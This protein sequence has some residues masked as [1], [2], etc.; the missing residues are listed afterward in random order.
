MAEIDSQYVRIQRAIWNKCSF[1]TLSDDGKLLFLYLDTC[2]HGN[3]MN[4]FVMPSGYACEDLGWKMERF[5][6]GLGELLGKRLVE[7][8]ETAGVI[9]DLNH[10][11]KFPPQNPNQVK[12]CIIKINELPKNKLFQTFINMVER[13]GEERNK[14]LLKRL[15][16]RLGEYVEVE[17]EVEVEEKGKNLGEKSKPK[18]KAV[19]TLW[20]DDFVLTDHLRALASK[21]IPDHLIET[22]WEAFKAYSLSNGKKYSS[23]EDAWKTRYLNYSKFNQGKAP[24]QNKAGVWR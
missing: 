20:P 7:Y 12:A 6:K 16:E 4:Y 24:E 21:Y 2:P 17:V 23:W 13:L 11:M 10:I 1:K 5:R 9:L 8:D 3:L 15:R 14:P 19:A 22:E 18:K